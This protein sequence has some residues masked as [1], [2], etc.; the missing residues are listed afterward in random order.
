MTRAAGDGRPF[1]VRTARSLGLRLA[2]VVV[3][4]VLVGVGTTVCFFVYQDLRQTIA[5]EESRLK[6]SAAA[7]AAAASNAIAAGDRRGTLEVLRGIRDLSHVTYADAVTGDGRILAEIGTA[8]T[9]VSR[10]R[11]LDHASALSVFLAD[12]MTASAEVRHGG[13]V[14]GTLSLH[15]DIAW[16][17][18]LYLHNLLVSLLVCAVVL[19]ATAIAA[20]SL[21][22]RIIRPLR[23]LTDEFADI[24]RRS[25]LSKRV[26]VVSEDEVGVLSSAFN[27]MFARIDERDRLLQR[28][29]ETLEETVLQRTAEMREARD[30][31]ERANAA[32]SEFLATVSH[33]IR[34]PMNGMLV[35]AE[36]LSTAPLAHRHKRYAGIILRSGRGLLNI[37]NDILDLSKIESGRLELEAIPISLDT[38]VEDVASLFGERA[39]EKGLSIALSVDPGVPAEVVGDPVRINQVLTNLVNNALKFTEKGGV[40]VTV[41]AAPHADDGRRSTIAF[42]VEDTGIGIAADKLGRLFDRFSQADQTIT[43]KF[44]GTGLG[45]AI[46]R[47]LVEAMGGTM[48]V[49]SEEG[50]GSSFGFDLGLEVVR[51]ADPVPSLAGRTVVLRDGDE[52]TARATTGILR[53]LGATVLG[54][55]DAGAARADA[56]LLREGELAALLEAATGSFGASAPSAPLVVLRDVRDAAST[57]PVLAPSRQPFEA[58]MALPLRR[59]E[60]RLLAEALRDGDFGRL[61]AADE[62]QEPL[63]A[64]ENFEDLRVLVVDDTEVNREVLKE[65]LASLRVAPELAEGGEAALALVRRQAF[66]LVFMDCSMPG[67]DGYAATRLLRAIEAEDGRRRARVVALTAHHGRDQEETWRA[68]GMDAY[69]TKPFTVPQIAA[70]LAASAGERAGSADAGDRPEQPRQPATAT[71]GAG[72]EVPLL[73][74]GT[75]ATLTSLAES[76]GP[77]VLERIV[78]LFTANAPKALADLRQAEEDSRSDG[79]ALAHALKSMCNSAGAGRAAAICEDIETGWKAGRPAGAA[80]LDQLEAALRASFDGLAALASGDAEAARRAG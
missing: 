55:G 58:E 6:S 17:R 9:L 32:K 44:G 49:A 73:D 7:F 46:S 76:N 10:D 48:Q 26:P 41:R 56:V 68:A 47:H 31:A 30:E 40:T 11:S 34:T 22:A 71:S 53:Q 43:R 74:A 27:D 2:A 23:A 15:A 14:V 45:L 64:A 39:A 13:I 79:A 67:M 62:S 72:D 21:V 54:D 66:D 28:H 3:L 29:R 42:D 37:L 35:M 36:M 57:E 59:S 75:V 69:L 60:I 25:D 20:W 24:G 80:T 1:R 12:T 51:D 4:A 38:L 33:E 16:L 65:A 50:R 63:P 52:I 77:G 5:A 70:A 61:R 8:A 78:G 19:L 18:A